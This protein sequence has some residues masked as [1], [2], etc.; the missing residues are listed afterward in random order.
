MSAGRGGPW[1]S[2]FASHERH[3]SAVLA[4]FSRVPFGVARRKENLAGAG[5]VSHGAADIRVK[6]FPSAVKIDTIR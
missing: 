1:P 6:R 2:G 4:V 3:S 5:P